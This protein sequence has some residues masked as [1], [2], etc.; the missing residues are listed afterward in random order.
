VG[1]ACE[2][3]TPAHLCE[4]T[5]AGLPCEQARAQGG[6]GAHEEA[7]GGLREAEDGVSDQGGAQGCGDRDGPGI[8]SGPLHADTLDAHV[9][10]DESDDGG[11]GSLP[12]QG[13]RLHGRRHPHEPGAVHD[14]AEECRLGRADPAHGGRQ[15]LRPE[16]PEHRDGQHGEAH[17]TRE[18][19][20]GPADPGQVR[21]AP[22]LHGEGA[23]GDEQRSVQHGGGGPATLGQR[24]EDRDDDRGAADEDAGDGGLGGPLGGE[25]GE[26]EADHADGRERGEPQPVAGGQEPQ[27]GEPVTAEQREEEQACG[28]VPKGLSTRVR[29]GAEQAVG[30]EGGTDEGVGEGH[31]E[32]PAQGVRVH[33]SDARERCGP[34]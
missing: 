23:G 17:L 9:E 6:S 30:G 20:R 34:R 13:S 28:A 8:E 19:H 18:R 1:R 24:D 26:V 15:E 5:P 32:D 3:T 10:E 21:P 16:D 33:A 25:D 14:Q 31:Q 12:E 22:A 2:Q 11:Q 27:R 29:V 4:Q 7:A